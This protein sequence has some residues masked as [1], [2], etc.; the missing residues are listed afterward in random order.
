MIANA[1]SDHSIVCGYGAVGEAAV[2]EL[3]RQGI[4]E[5]AIV[6]VDC[7]EA[8]V[9]RAIERAVT[10]LA[11]NATANATLDAACIRRARA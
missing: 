7:D 1:L 2:D 10:V 6:V 9:A 11:G 5:R 3:L 4:A 8:R